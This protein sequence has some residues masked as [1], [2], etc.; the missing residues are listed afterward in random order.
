MSQQI[1]LSFSNDF[2]GVQVI[3]YSEQDDRDGPFFVKTIYEDP[4][5]HAGDESEI[6]VQFDT[7]AA[8]R[9][10]FLEKVKEETEALENEF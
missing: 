10:A 8:A 1:L 7:C 4:A 9:A 2:D 5:T 6:T 3:L